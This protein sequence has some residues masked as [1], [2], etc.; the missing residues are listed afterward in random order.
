MKIIADSEEEKQKIL[1]ASKHIHDFTVIVYDLSEDSEII[2]VTDSDQVVVADEKLIK[3][4]KSKEP[5]IADDQIF[6]S[7]PKVAYKHKIDDR[8]CEQISFDMYDN[9]VVDSRKLVEFILNK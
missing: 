9:M 4:V 5:D 8:E 2:V 7:I 3:D 1:K 6:E